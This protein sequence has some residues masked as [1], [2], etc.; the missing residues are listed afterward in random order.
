MLA[1]RKSGGAL[2]SV[3][4]S[5]LRLA[6]FE[7]PRRQG[8][9]L[10]NFKIKAWATATKYTAVCCAVS[11][12]CMPCF[13]RNP[14]RTCIPVLSNPSALSLRL[15]NGCKVLCL[16]CVKHFCLLCFQCFGRR[17]DPRAH[18]LWKT[19]VFPWNGRRINGAAMERL[20]NQQAPHFFFIAFSL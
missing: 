19:N 12:A 20:Q 17:R 1:F 8:N 16:S 7:I 6:N 5:Y 11:P 4:C 3:K 15:G 9:G 2:R 14:Q 13:H 10:S 18:C